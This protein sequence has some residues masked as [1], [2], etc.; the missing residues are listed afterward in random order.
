MQKHTGLLNLSGPI[1]L[2][3]YYSFEMKILFILLCLLFLMSC[4]NN[5]GY[6]IYHGFSGKFVYTKRD[7]TKY[8]VFIL[9]SDR[10]RQITFSQFDKIYPQWLPDGKKIL[11]LSHDPTG[12]NIHVMDS[13]GMH[14]KFLYNSGQSSVSSFFY[15][16]MYLSPDGQSVVVERADSIF[17]FSIAEDLQVRKLNSRDCI[18][19]YMYVAWSRDSRMFSCTCQ[20]ASDSL[21]HLIVYDKVIDQFRDLTSHFGRNVREQSWSYNSTWIAFRDGFDIYLIHPDGTGLKRI[22]VTSPYYASSIAFSPDDDRLAYVRVDSLYDL[23]MYNISAESTDILLE[24]KISIG[25]PLMWIDDDKYVMYR[26]NEG[27]YK[28]EENR[29]FEI[30]TRKEHTIYDD[31]GSSFNWIQD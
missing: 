18:T 6:S 26:Y 21:Q 10:V 22:D 15:P 5:D 16:S 13:I 3:E 7:Q 4:E 31:K 8:Q 30:A 24:E 12:I 14:D 23:V 17:I 27:K 20:G 2:K 25:G 28:T 19:K 11:F 29:L 9:N 1:F